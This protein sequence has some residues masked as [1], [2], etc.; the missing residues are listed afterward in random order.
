MGYYCCIIVNASTVGVDVIALIMHK[1][2]N[3]INIAKTI[4]K[5]NII[6]LFVGLIVYGVK[7]III[8]MIF[9]SIYSRIL[10]YFLKVNP[11]KVSKSI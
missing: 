6:V 1:K 5:I 11:L 2:N 10:E 3:N 9:T 8:G 4:S 7:S